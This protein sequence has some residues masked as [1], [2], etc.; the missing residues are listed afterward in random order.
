MSLVWKAIADYPA[1]EISNRG[2][3]R[4]ALPPRLRGANTVGKVLKW[5]VSKTGHSLVHLSTENGRKALSVHR[6]VLEAFVGPAP[7]AKH[8]AAHN[9]GNPLNNSVENL[10]WATMRENHADKAAHGTLLQGESH[11]RRKLSAQQVNE[12]RSCQD[13]QKVIAARYGIAQG[14][15]HKIKSGQRW[16]CTGGHHA[17]A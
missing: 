17:S 10:R 11:P 2:D 13:T 5:N 4:R 1:Y 15:V 6:A 16:K 8:V 3:V 14:T 9:D 12:I 7:S